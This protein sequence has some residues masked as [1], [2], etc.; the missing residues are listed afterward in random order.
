MRYR[1][2][3]VEGRAGLELNDAINQTVGVDE[4]IV[5]ASF[6]AIERGPENWRT[7]YSTATLLI[8]RPEPQ[9][10]QEH[11]DAYGTWGHPR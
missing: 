7:T 3:T 8:E 5:S 4:R 6:G 9:V 2:V 11:L 1:V 10:P